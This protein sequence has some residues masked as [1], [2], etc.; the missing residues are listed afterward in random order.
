MV[1][2][3]QAIVMFLVCLSESVKVSFFFTF[4]FHSSQSILPT[5]ILGF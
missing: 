2:Y 1:E 3:I 5:E 4:D